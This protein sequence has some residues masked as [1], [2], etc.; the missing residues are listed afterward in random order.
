MAEL[1]KRQYKDLD[2]RIKE[3]KDWMT[4]QE[5]SL[6]ERSLLSNFSFLTTVME[7][8]QSAI[9]SSKEQINHLQNGMA[10]NYQL[11]EEFVNKE[12]KKESWDA[13]LDEKR[14]EAQR[15]YEEENDPNFKLKQELAEAEAEA[16]SEEGGDEET[17][18]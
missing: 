12:E 9:E 18:D 11:V 13:F 2:K 5:A 17:E 6:S 7:R 3:I 16:E 4:E 15:K 14:E 8:Y 1:N 10:E